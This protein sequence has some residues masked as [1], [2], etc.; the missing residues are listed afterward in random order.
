[1]VV[2]WRIFFEYVDTSQSERA[3]SLNYAVWLCPE[4]FSSCFVY[5]LRELRTV[6]LHYVVHFQLDDMGN[7]DRPGLVVFF[8]T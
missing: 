7:D 8:F 3:C 2:G 1:M 6:T 5:S 4:G